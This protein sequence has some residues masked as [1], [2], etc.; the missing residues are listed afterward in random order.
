MVVVL[1]SSLGSVVLIFFIECVF[2]R[3]KVFLVVLGLKWK[4]F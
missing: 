4:L 3:L 1:V 2:F